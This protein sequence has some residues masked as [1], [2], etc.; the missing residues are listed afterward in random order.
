MSPEPDAMGIAGT[1]GS[2]SVASPTP[3]AGL[4]VDVQVAFEGF[5]LAGSSRRSR[6][7]A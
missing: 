6:R 3:E 4:E 5:D 1:A 2:G 7:L